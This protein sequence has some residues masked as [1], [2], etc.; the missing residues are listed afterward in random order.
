MNFT[1]DERKRMKN[2]A[3]KIHSSGIFMGLVTENFMDSGEVAMQM[4]FA[5]LMDK[6]I[7]LLVLKNAKVPE[8][9]KKIAYHIE[10]VDPDE[11][12]SMISASRRLLDKSVEVIQ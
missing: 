4:G 11:K 12:D 5:I 10:Y 1:D 2:T 9:L 8:H 3:E 6:P 7:G